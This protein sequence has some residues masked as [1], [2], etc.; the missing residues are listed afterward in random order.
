VSS[1]EP[2]AAA[3]A[4]PAQGTADR[5]M[6]TYRRAPRRFAFGAGA[7]LV[8]EDHRRHLDLASGIGASCLGHGHPGL[9][10]AIAG[11]AGRLVHASNL[12]RTA[13]GEELSD[14]LCAR[15]GMDAVFFSNSGAEANEA[16]IK[17]ARKVQVLRGQPERQRIVALE[18]GFH[19]RTFGSL[20]ATANEAYRAPFGGMLEASFVAPG[21]L[22]GLARAL[23]GAAALIMEPVLGEGGLIPL[24]EGFLRGAREACDRAGALLVHDEIQSGGG[25][26]GAYLA[27]EH[28]GVTP[29]VVTLAKPLAGGVPIGATLARGEAATALVPGDHGST[30]G[31]GPLACAAAL[32]VLDELDAGLDARV[33]ELGDALASGLDR[34]ADASPIALARRG[35]GLMQGLVLPS[36]VEASRAVAQL[37]DPADGPPVL[38]CTAAGG[39]L[40]LLPP[41]VLTDDDL[42]VGLAQIAAALDALGEPRT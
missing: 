39:V 15:T 17:I 34:I 20:S 40:R 23:D 8:D 10:A 2:Q 35:L 4:A 32:A 9:T 12:Y 5:T 36:A 13:P 33:R 29:D 6:G 24:C 14:R 25:R 30:F 22:D 41:F 1:L 38:A 7:W 21:D 42:E 28:A 27:A 31:G 18:G 16:A 37:M 11:Q 3:T 26:T 19:G